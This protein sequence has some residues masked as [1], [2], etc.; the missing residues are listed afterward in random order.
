MVSSCF[1]DELIYVRSIKSMK[2]A[3]NHFFKSIGNYISAKF[4]EGKRLVIKKDADDKG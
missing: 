1:V 4:F 2:K 3:G